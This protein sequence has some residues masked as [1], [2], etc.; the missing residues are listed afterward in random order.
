MA[1]TGRLRSGGR[2]SG[3]HCVRV[4]R[5]GHDYGYYGG[6]GFEHAAGRHNDGS[7]GTSADRGQR[8]HD[9]DLFIARP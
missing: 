5:S 9:E 7:P 4:D 2:R 1:N 3:H 8:V 6:P